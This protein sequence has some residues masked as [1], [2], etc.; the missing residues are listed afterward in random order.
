[1][2]RAVEKYLEDPLAEEILR[3]T[4]IEGDPVHVTADGDKLVFVQ[5]KPTAEGA[6]EG[7]LKS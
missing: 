2:R 5:N 3:G 7:A 6:A 4:L 1:M